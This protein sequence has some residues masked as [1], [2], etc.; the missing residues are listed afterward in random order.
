MP[1]YFSIVSECNRDNIYG[2]ILKDFYEVLTIAG[3]KFTYGYWQS[4]DMSYEE[5]IETNQK[6]LEENFELGYDENSDND[7]IQLM[8]DFGDFSEVR[9]FIMNR[10]EEGIFTL[11]IIIPE[12]ELLEIR[13]GKITYDRKKTDSLIELSKKLWE[14][15]FVDIIQTCLE[16]SD[17]IDTLENIKDG[18]ALAVEPFAIV[19]DE[20]KELVPG[21]YSTSELPGN[22][23]LV[24]LSL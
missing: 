9:S 15:P 20:I 13:D 8:Y 19:P 14:L 3:M 18:A 12:D 2:T 4:M 11:H 5:I 17:D 16:L 23:M 6:K 24:T 7:Y 10:P 21:N 22:G 1:A